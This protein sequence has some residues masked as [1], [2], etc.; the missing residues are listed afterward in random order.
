VLATGTLD[1]LVGGSTIRIRATNL[2]P[3]DVRE[4]S[5]FGRVDVGADDWLAIEAARGTDPTPDLVA[6][7]VRRGGRIHAV[8]DGRRSLEDRYLELVGRDSGDAR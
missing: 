5:V 6:W 3:D 2:S 1:E 7:I 8:E 4:L